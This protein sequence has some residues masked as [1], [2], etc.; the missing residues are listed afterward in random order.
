MS[1]TIVKWPFG[2]ASKVALSASGAQEIEIVNDLTIVD[3]ATIPAT[4]DRVLN[5]KI[6]DTVSAGAMILVKSKTTAAEKTSFGDKI[7][8]PEITGVAGKTN[9]ACF[10][11]D[12]NDFVQ[13][14][15]AVQVD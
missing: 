10:I 9:V 15:A 14:G 5:I 1:D 7:T 2:A 11:H 8:G 13:T 3:G 6:A 4:G 12:G